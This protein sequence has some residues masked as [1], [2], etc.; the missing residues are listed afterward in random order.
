MLGAKSA[1]VRKLAAVFIT[2]LTFV[3]TFAQKF[4][5]FCL[6]FPEALIDVLK[7]GTKVKV[8]LSKTTGF[9]LKLI[10]HFILKL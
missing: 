3:A 8:L 2:N 7:H 9:Y 6:Y 10:G 1:L 5:H 4:N